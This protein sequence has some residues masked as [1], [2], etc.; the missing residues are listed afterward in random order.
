MTVFRFL[1]GALD[2][3]AD[4][5]PE[6][7]T[8][9]ND[10]TWNGVTCKC[11]CPTDGAKYLLPD[12]KC[13]YSQANLNILNSNTS[14]STTIRSVYLNKTFIFIAISNYNLVFVTSPKDLG[15]FLLL[16][17]YY[18]WKNWSFKNEYNFQW[19]MLTVNQS[20]KIKSN[21]VKIL[22]YNTFIGIKGLHIDYKVYIDYITKIIFSVRHR[23]RASTKPFYSIWFITIGIFCASGL[24]MH[25][26]NDIWEMKNCKNGWG[27]FTWYTVVLQKRSLA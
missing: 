21:F 27:K 6:V 11:D 8:C 19:I 26:G 25:G 22:L 14:N 18:Y 3:F 17:A 24:L 20:P 2:Y 7:N 5:C 13:K 4:D 9:L 12:C 10:G 16:F 1:F 15:R 23:S